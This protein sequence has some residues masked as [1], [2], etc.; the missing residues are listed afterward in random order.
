M[1][2]HAVSKKRKRRKRRRKGRGR[3]GEGEEG[4]E[5]GGGGGGGR[6][7]RG[8][9]GGGGRRREEEGG[10]EGGGGGGGGGRR[11]RNPKDPHSCESK[12]NLTLKDFSE[13]DLSSIQ[14]L[15][16]ETQKVS[17]VHHVSRLRVLSQIHKDSNELC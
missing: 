1:K 17:D 11:R 6:G 5:G 16:M 14:H 3:R 7:R 15:H 4:G 13:I 9:E 2:W 10:E 8:E 12:I